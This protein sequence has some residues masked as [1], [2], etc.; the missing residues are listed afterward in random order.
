MSLSVIG[1]YFIIK[2]ALKITV[3]IYKVTFYICTAL[4]MHEDFARLLTDGDEKFKAGGNLPAVT[5]QIS[6]GA[7]TRPLWLGVSSTGVVGDC[8]SS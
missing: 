5:Q 7:R 4:T 8:G 2:R 1:F 6:L 3:I